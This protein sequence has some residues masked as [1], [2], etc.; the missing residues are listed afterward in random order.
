MQ[1]S[2]FDF[3]FEV[4]FRHNKKLSEILWIGS[5]D[6]TKLFTIEE[7]YK[8]LGDIMNEGKFDRLKFDPVI[9][10]DTWWLS[11]CSN[12]EE[13]HWAYHEEDIPK[14]NCNIEWSL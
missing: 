13:A 4:I 5:R 1:G 12:G 7:L 9:V 8:K 10:G 3:A 6:G 14:K 2:S 11:I